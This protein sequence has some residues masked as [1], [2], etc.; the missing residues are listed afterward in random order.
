MEKLVRLDRNRKESREG[1]TS[2]RLRNGLAEG[3]VVLGTLGLLS[4]GCAS[5]VLGSGKARLTQERA[6][7]SSSKGD[8]ASVRAGDASL[9][10]QNFN[11]LPYVSAGVDVT[12]QGKAQPLVSF[13]W[14]FMERMEGSNN[15]YL[16][17]NP[18][19]DRDP[20]TGWVLVPDGSGNVIRPGDNMPCNSETRQP[21]PGASPV[22]PPSQYIGRLLRRTGGDVIVGGVSGQGTV[23][24]RVERG[25][26]G[27]PTR[28][29]VR[30]DLSS[31]VLDII[32][33]VTSGPM[34]TRAST[35]GATF[36]T[37][38]IRPQ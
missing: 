25:A 9:Y 8:T 2:T 37:V 27:E 13:H 15:E 18:R 22:T 23:L 36:V 7:A 5:T 17:L 14:I 19:W 38:L 26:A 12:V 11:G 28:S 16:L 1:K 30:G 33:S 4:A 29:P 34:K 32:S 35:G 20:R 6:S 3:L 10:E 24:A 21:V 31:E